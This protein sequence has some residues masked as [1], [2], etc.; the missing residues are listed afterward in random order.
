MPDPRIAPIPPCSPS[1]GRRSRSFRTE[2]GRSGNRPRCERIRRRAGR[3]RSRGAAHRRDRDL[4]GDREASAGPRH[5]DDRARR[6]RRPRSHRRRRGRG[7]A[8]PRSGEGLGRRARARAHRGRV[9]APAGDPGGPEKLV[10]R[11]GQRGRI[12]VEVIPLARGL[13]ARELRALGLTPTVRPGADGAPFHTDN[14]NLTLDCAPGA[15]LADGAAARAL[16]AAILAVPGVVDTGLFL[17]TAERVLVGHP[18]GR[19]EVRTRGGHVS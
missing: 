12:P 2:P 3:T 13:V 4:G 5:L 8:Q 11:L 19:V 7:G 6:G 15:P 14:G 16:E 1:P 9:V 17:G 18:D 10:D